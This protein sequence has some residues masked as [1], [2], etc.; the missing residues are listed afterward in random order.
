MKFLSGLEKGHPQRKRSTPTKW[1]TYVDKKYHISELCLSIY[2][3][4]LQ[5]YIKSTHMLRG[6]N[7]VTIS[8]MVKQGD[9]PDA[10]KAFYPSWDDNYWKVN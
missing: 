7:S 4:N 9:E 3:L 6:V 2:L 10:F 1:R 5:D 8:I